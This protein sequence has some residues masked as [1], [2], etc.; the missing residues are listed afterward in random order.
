LPAIEGHV[1]SEVVCCFCAFLEFCYIACS[2]TITEDTIEKLED[3]LRCFHHYQ[4]IFQDTG[5]RFD[6]S[7]PWQHS[8]THY[9]L[10]ICLFGAPNGLCSSITE[11]KHIEDVK[12]PWR[13]S[14]QYNALLQM[15]V[16]NQ[17][18]DK[19]AAAQAD[20]Q[21]RGM[22]NG[23]LS[24]ARNVMHGMLY[25]TS[26]FDFAHRFSQEGQVNTRTMMRHTSSLKPLPRPTRKV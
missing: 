18:L 11:S 15:L 4:S 25:V 9:S 1:P 10:L 20:F 14:N 13:R 22:L 21:R 17:Q 3:V 7:L 26:T 24:D 8:M 23:N 19:L 16:T 5:V 12:L 2:D 6:I